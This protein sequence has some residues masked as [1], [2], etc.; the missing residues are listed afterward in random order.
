MNTPDHQVRDRTVYVVNVNGTLCSLCKK[1]DG[2]GVLLPSGEHH[3]FS[4]RAAALA[5]IARTVS[6]QQRVRASVIHDAAVMA[7]LLF[8][9]AMAVETFR[10]RAN[11]T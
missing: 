3:R 2:R 11:S 8:S 1:Y 7:P 6:A 9:G 10:L 5:A 4:T